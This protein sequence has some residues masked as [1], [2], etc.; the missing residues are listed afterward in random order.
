MKCGTL[1]L[2]HRSKHRPNQPTHLVPVQSETFSEHWESLP[3]ESQW[4]PI[5][6]T[7]NQGWGSSWRRTR[8]NML[9]FFFKHRKL[10]P[11]QVICIVY[12]LPSPWVGYTHLTITF[13]WYTKKLS[14]GEKITSIFIELN[15]LGNLSKHLFPWSADHP[16]SAEETT[17]PPRKG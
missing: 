5:E 7:K 11:D 9:S 1:H 2:D 15:Y 17:E 4:S 8:R 13:I 3:M 14:S 6:V 16:Y 10:L 12:F